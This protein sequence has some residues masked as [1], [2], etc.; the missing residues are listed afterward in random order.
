VRGFLTYGTYRL[1]GALA[2]PLPPEI[3]YRMARPAGALFHAL[4]PR[5][6]RILSHNFRHVLGAD[7]GEDQVQALVHKACTNIMK[8]HYDLFRLSR[9][10]TDEICEIT[11]I[12][13]IEYMEQALA[14]GKGVILISAHFGNIDILGQVPLAYGVPF[15]APV[16]HTQPERLFQYTLKLRQSHGLRLF[17]ADGPLMELYR[18]LGRGEMIGLPCDRGISDNTRAVKFFGATAFLPEGPVRLALRTGAAL[19]PAFGLRLPDNTFLA[20]VEPPLELARTGDREA[21]ITAGLEMVVEVLE[22]TISQYPDQWLVAAPV[23][24]MD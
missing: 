7:A 3:G 19:V 17:P 23:W 5:F 12:E 14:L 22:R 9:L 24:P 6:R 4:S 10:S 18:A 13:G 21:D 2:G 15:S 1:L 20:W 8:G 11:K 16:Q